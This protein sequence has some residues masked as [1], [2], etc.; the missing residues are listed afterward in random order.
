MRLPR[1]F[2]AFVRV[3]VFASDHDDF[4]HVCG[5]HAL[6]GFQVAPGKERFRA[7]V[8]IDEHAAE[9]G[10][11]AVGER[12]VEQVAVKEDE[13]TC[14]DFDGDGVVIRVGKSEGFM[15]AVKT[16][17]VLYVLGPQYAALVRAGN[18]P[19]AAVFCGGIVE[20]KPAAG[21]CSVSGGNVGFILVPCLS[22]FSRAFDKEHGLHAFD[23]GADDACETIDHHGMGQRV[24]H[25]RRVSVYV[26]DTQDTFDY[27]VVGVIGREGGQITHIAALP[28][29]QGCG[30]VAQGL[31][32]FG[33]ECIG[34]YE[35]S[36]F[37]VKGHVVFGDA[38]GGFVGDGGH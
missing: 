27:V 10:F 2:G 9:A 5:C 31:D 38:R 37:A 32:F 1:Y 30:F 12:A 20:G 14:F 8:V 6:A 7:H 26:V 18:D 4:S 23:I 3:W 16:V 36:I 24:V 15:G 17:V 29:T 33:G 21:E 35:V 13:G 22:G 34:D 28:A 25:K 19:Q 11:G